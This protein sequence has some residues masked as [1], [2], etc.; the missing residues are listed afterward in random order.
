MIMSDCMSAPSSADSRTS[1]V[2]LC[3]YGSWLRGV[4]GV[5]GVEDIHADTGEEFYLLVYA[6]AYI[7]KKKQR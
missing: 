3:R 2:V 1:I 7:C 5:A 4:G 6:I